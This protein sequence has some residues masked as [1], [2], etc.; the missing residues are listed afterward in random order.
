[1]TKRKSFIIHIDSLN[2]L[3]ELSDDQAGKLFKAIK[4]HQLGDEF[5]FDALTRIAF[6]P[7]KNQFSRDD[8]KY[9]KLC[10]KNRLIAEKRYSTKPTTGVSGNDSLPSTTKSTDNDSKSKSD[11]KNDSDSNS[12]EIVTKSAK[13]N[14]SFELFKYWCDV[15]GKNISTSKLTPK[16]DKA[17]KARLKEGYSFEQIK[18]AI[19]GCR[20]DPFSMGQNDR[21][22]KFNDIEL[23]CRS[24]EKLESFLEVTVQQTGNKRDINAIGTDFSTIPEGFNREK[25]Y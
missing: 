9:I 11:S 14:P 18:E 13:A 7:F 12:K 2:I 21:Q 5:E 6:S 16:R 23:I 8:E 1:M 20:N 22:K 17:I 24:G 3:D 25:P 4:A 10:E 19:N 15:M